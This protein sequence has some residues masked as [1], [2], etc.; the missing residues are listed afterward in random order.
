MVGRRDLHG[1]KVCLGRSQGRRERA[2]TSGRVF[3]ACLVSSVRSG[4]VYHFLRKLDKNKDGKIDTKELIKKRV[5][6][7]FKELDRNKDGKISREEARAQ[8]KDV[9]PRLP[10][11]PP[12]E[13]ETGPSSGTAGRR[14]PAGPPPGRRTIRIPS[15]FPLLASLGPP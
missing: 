2:H 3:A 14:S 11:P 7:I 15:S 6:G 9:A 13:L 4:R 5:D 1:V 10:G 8:I 12:A